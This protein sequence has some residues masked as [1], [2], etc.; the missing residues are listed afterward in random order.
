MSINTIKHLPKT[1]KQ[2]IFLYIVLKCLFIYLCQYLNIISLSPIHSETI[3]I[4]INY[5]SAYFV[6]PLLI[7]LDSTYS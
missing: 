3:S 2:Y 1:Y 6:S 5:C 7:A 4:N